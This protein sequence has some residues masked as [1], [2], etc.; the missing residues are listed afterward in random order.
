[1][2][3]RQF[4]RHSMPIT[5]SIRSVSMFSL[6]LDLNSAVFQEIFPFAVLCAICR[7]L[8]SLPGGPSS[9][10]VLDFT[11]PNVNSDVQLYYQIACDY[12]LERYEDRLFKYNLSTI[13]MNEVD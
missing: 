6:V 10:S 4:Y 11:L 2:I 7:H 5:Y 8:S 3:L 1:M 9:S 13:S 12:F